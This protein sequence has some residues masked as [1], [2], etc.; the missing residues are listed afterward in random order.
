MANIEQKLQSNL[1]AKLF[2]LTLDRRAPK[3]LHLQLADALRDIILSGGAL[4]GARL[5]ASRGLAGELSV[6]RM[7]VTT[8][9]DQLL[10]EGYLSA[11]RGGG[12]FVAD[13]LP[14]LAPPRGVKPRLPQRSADWRPFQPGLPDWALFPH[15][16]WARHLERSWRAPAPGLLAQPDPLGWFPLRAAISEHLSAW[17]GLECDPEQVVITGGAWD[18]FD[19]VFRAILAPGQNVAVED[20]GWSPLR[21]M[22]TRSDITP[23]P[24]RVGTDGLDA[25]DIARDIAA[26]VVTPSRHFPTGVSM[27]LARRVTLLDWARST[28]A[29][30]VEDDY[31]SEFRYQGQPLP[32]LSGLDG[33]RNTLYLGSFSKLLSPALRIGYLVVPTAQIDPVRSYLSLTGSRASLVPQPALATFMDSGEFAT[34]LRRM[35]RTYAKRQACLVSA[36]APLAD[37]LVVTPDPS[38]MHLCC[39]LAPALADIATDKDVSELGA[40]HGLTV[41]ALSSHAVL[42]DPPQGVLLGYAA[43]DEDALRESAEVLTGL[44]RQVHVR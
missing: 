26:A 17:R 36:L 42:P 18:A 24:I 27:S 31:D 22:L 21:H 23:V 44:I 29:L 6:S 25:H 15:R 9:Y 10:G 41:R 19:I 7:T 16:I 20:P 43:F 34:H 3:P 35:R 28:R 30:I 12:T 32:S 5:P 39:P 14:H 2:A 4:S 33:L 11:R 8:A 37:D 40:A 1:D 13:H 38:G